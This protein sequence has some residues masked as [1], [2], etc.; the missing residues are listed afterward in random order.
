MLPSNMRVR[1]KKSLAHDHFITTAHVVEEW[2]VDDQADFI[3]T[4][5]TIE[6]TH[7]PNEDNVF[8][9]MACNSDC[10]VVDISDFKFE[11]A[12]CGTF[13]K[14]ATELAEVQDATLRIEP[15]ETMPHGECVRCGALCYEREKE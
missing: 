14:D 11:C 5:T 15:G 10:E 9:C 8:S 12:N 3:S 13:Y 1:C 4:S 6:T 2:E 7:A